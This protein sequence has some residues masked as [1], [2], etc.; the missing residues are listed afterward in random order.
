MSEEK[1]IVTPWEVRG[2]IDYDKLIKEFGTKRITDELLNRVKKHTGE[3]HPFLRRKLFFSHRDFDWILDEYE[4]GDKFFLYTGRGP[5][6]NTHIGHLIPWIFTKWL[7]DKFDVELYF[8]ITEDEKSLV[9]DLTLEETKSIAYENI[10]DVIAIGFDPKKTHI[11]L[12]TEYIKT[13]YPIAV[14]IAKH[15]TFSTVKAVFGFE[16]NTNI[17]LSFFP[18][19]QIA[20][21]FLPSVLKKKNI[22][23]LIPAAIDQDD[24][25]RPARDIA[26]KLGFYK[27]AQIHSKL[28]TSLQGPL[29]KMSSSDPNSAVFTTDLP[30]VVKEKI[31]KYAYSGGQATVAEHRKKGGNP[32][33]DVSYQWLTFFEED[34]KKLKEIY[35]NYKSGRLLTGELK[36]ILVEKINAFLKE[37]QRRREKAKDLIDKFMLRD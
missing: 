12:D 3:L 31:V 2:K 7:Q 8:Q 4:K 15:I 23:C 17:G 5:S 25:W 9:K 37:H 14:K 27:P 1:M 16:N 13:L 34:D 18:S 10:L 6:G 22:P 21:C 26:P 32:D 20:P 24:Y 30:E 35:E 11:F 19:I 36:L 33:V 29:A 28:I